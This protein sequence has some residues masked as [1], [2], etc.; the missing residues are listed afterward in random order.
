M[1]AH[2]APASTTIVPAACPDQLGAFTALSYVGICAWKVAHER[3]HAPRSLPDP[4]A[5]E[6]DER[7]NDLFR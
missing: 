3:G 1:R 5:E 4:I 7:V 2:G 6:R